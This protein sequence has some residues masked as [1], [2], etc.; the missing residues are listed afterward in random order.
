MTQGQIAALKRRGV[1]A[2]S[3]EEAE[4]FLAGLVTN[5]VT[6]IPNGGAG[7]GGLLSPQGK[8]LF[9]FIVFRIGGEFLFDLPKS[10]IADFVKRLGLYKLRAK[11]AIAAL[12]DRQVVAAWGATIPPA[13]DGLAAPDPRLPSLGYRLILPADGPVESAGFETADEV[14]YD[15]QRIELGIPEGAIDFTYGEAFPHEADMD[16]LGGVAFDKGCYIGQEVVS[17]M[18]HRG[19]ARRRLIQVRSASP[20]P[21]AGAEIVAGEKPVGTIASSSPDHAG[22]AVVRL[23][24]AKEALDAGVPLLV[25]GMPVDLDIPAWAKFGWPSGAV[26]D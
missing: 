7:Y 6:A 20:I 13:I 14:A 2:V 25:R 26:R 12:P 18:E 5:D 8:I 19:T 10:A 21:P 16:Q 24:R 11:V 23:D 22:L 17:R 4:S 1:V 9:D 3:G 15:A